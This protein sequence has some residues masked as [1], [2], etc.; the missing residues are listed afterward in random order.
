MRAWWIPDD[1]TC[2]EVYDL[3]SIFLH[4]FRSRFYVPTGAP[5]TRGKSHEFDLLVLIHAE[6]PFPA[7]QSAEALTTSASMIAMTDD[8]SYFGLLAHGFFL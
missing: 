1:H 7:G 2:G 4:L 6:C 8:D 3:R 5:I